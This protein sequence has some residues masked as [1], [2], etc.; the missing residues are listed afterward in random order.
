M[1][2]TAPEVKR[3]EGWLAGGGEM[4]ALIRSF[5]W[6]RTAIGPIES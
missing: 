5:D 4:G 2:K 1:T 3:T 6:S